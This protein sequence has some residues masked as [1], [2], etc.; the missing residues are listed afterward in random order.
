MLEHLRRLV[1][2]TEDLD[3]TS[4]LGR[5]G[6]PNR[7]ESTGVAVL[8]PWTGALRTALP[9]HRAVVHRCGGDE[10]YALGPGAA[11]G[12]WIQLSTW[13]THRRPQHARCLAQRVAQLVAHT[14]M[15]AMI[16]C[17]IATRRAAA[18]HR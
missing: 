11:A 7:L 9:R 17:S 2:T 5:Y 10:L 4:F 1:L 18:A 15:W 3:F 8:H 16:S 14:C 6:R 13:Q 12:A